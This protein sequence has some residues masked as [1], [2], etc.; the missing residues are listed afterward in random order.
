MVLVPTSL[1][2]AARVGACAGDTCIAAV[3]AAV[4]LG[5]DCV[6]DVLAGSDIGPCEVNVV[7]LVPGC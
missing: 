1:V 5:N 7:P 2:A 6:V 4:C 3:E